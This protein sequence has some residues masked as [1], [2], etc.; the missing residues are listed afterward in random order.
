MLGWCAYCQRYLGE[1]PP[2]ER[3]DVTHGV[4]GPC[5]R[6]RRFLDAGK[7]AGVQ[8]IAD[9]F[10]ELRAR[11]RASRDV[12]SSEL[13]ERALGLGVRPL[14]LLVGLLQPALYEIGDLWERGPVSVAA[15][16]RFSAA[17]QDVVGLVR[18]RL[19][20]PSPDAPVRFLLV[21]AEDNAHTIGP[22][23]VE[24]MLRT[25]GHHVVCVSPGLPGD[26]ILALVATMRPRVLGVS[27][28]S[29]SQL[30]SVRHVARGLEGLNAGHRP[31]LVVGG[32]AV[33]AGLGVPTDPGYELVADP[34]DLLSLTG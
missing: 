17:A 29:P 10:G 28:S 19:P 13:L 21:L 34:S 20:A 27:V 33:K 8:P 2:L 24:V 9:L 11:A 14:D 3:F 23:I 26:E 1:V 5:T 22:S 30:S 4:C 25:Q 31:R 15:E 12:A 18:Q 32:F 16:H 6:E 7:V